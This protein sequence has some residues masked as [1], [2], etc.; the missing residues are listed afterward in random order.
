VYCKHS[1]WERRMGRR[2][3]WDMAGRWVGVKTP[4]K[5][6]RRVLLDWHAA[7]KR[8]IRH[9]LSTTSRPPDRH[10][11]MLEFRYAEL[12]RAPIPEIVWIRFI[13]SDGRK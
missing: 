1:G 12:R 7:S 11:E 3:G 2:G 10:V 6:R 13:R 9:R 4:H 5:N 8:Q